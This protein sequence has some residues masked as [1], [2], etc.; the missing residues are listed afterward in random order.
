MIRIVLADDH[1]LVREGLKQL[2]QAAPDL[3]VV[4]EAQDGH[5]ALQRV[6]EQEFELLLLDM[7]M[8]GRSGI[9]LIK[10][11][12]GEKPRLRILVLSMHEERQY[13]IRA[14]RAGASGYL[15]KDSASAQLVS[16]IRKVAGGG[17]YISAEVAEQLALDAMPQAH[18][19]P[20]TTLSDREYEVFQLLV[21]GVAVTDIAERLH[22]S[23]KTVSTHK[24]R[25]LQKMGMSNPA[26]LVRYAIAQRLI[27]EAGKPL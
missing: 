16:A 1:T 10:Q 25:L 19:L 12:K 22:L 27:D 5:Q 11:I 18:G 4:G 15:T 26:E 13:A 3:A 7:S 20:H 2:L 9:E 24:A 14:I 8:P 21:A 6:R 23:V 17:A